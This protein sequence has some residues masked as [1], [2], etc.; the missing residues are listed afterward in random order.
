MCRRHGGP[1]FEARRCR[2]GHFGAVDFTVAHGGDEHVVVAV[3]VAVVGDPGRAFGIDGDSGLPIVR[4]A[5]GHTNVRRPLCA[6]ERLEKDVAVLAAKALPDDRELTLAIRRHARIDIRQRIP[7]QPLDGAPLL[8]RR[9]E[10]ARIDV[11]VPVHLL[12]PDHP[13]RDSTHP[14]PLAAGSCRR[15]FRVPTADCPT[16]R[17]CNGG[18]R[19]RRGRRQSSARRP[20]ATRRE[21]RRSKASHP[22]GTGCPTAVELIWAQEGAA[23]SRSVARRSRGEIIGVHYSPC[24]YRATSKAKS[25]IILSSC[26]CARSLR[27]S[28]CWLS[29]CIAARRVS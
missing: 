3:L 4:R 8:L 22:G 21:R 7:G 24:G 11:P 2:D 25:S 20:T 28:S 5:S 18:W 26:S 19:R 27:S 14:R 1:G 12:R 29:F 10:A 23:M 6:V 13:I 17:R 9:V 15:W 16:C